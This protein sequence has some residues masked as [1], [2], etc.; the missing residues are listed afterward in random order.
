MSKAGARAASR[1]NRSIQSE[2]LVYKMLRS[3]F[4][5]AIVARPSGWLTSTFR[6]A[7]CRDTHNSAPQR[8]TASNVVLPGWGVYGLLPVIA[9]SSSQEGEATARANPFA[10]ATSDHGG[11]RALLSC[12]LLVCWQLVFRGLALRCAAPLK[13]QQVQR[14]RL[15]TS[16]NG[17]TGM[18]LAAM[19]SLMIE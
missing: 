15:T 4:S 11:C 1:F 19:M 5:A 17:E 8:E 6:M 2:P 12:N 18:R 7:I 10:S 3:E 14:R 9:V 13:G 16:K